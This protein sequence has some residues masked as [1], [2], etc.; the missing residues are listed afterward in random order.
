VGKYDAA[1][2]AT[3]DNKTRRMRFACWITKATD[4]HSE[5]LILIAF[6]RLRESA[7]MLRYM[8]ISSLVYFKTRPPHSMPRLRMR[9]AIP[10]LT[11]IPFTTVSRSKGTILFQFSRVTTSSVTAANNEVQLILC[12]NVVIQLLQRK[13][14][15]G[16]RNF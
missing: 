14:K 12:S 2:E 5:Y 13:L 15:A 11:P 3:R 6:P 7:F 8:Y 10:P 4:T 1:Q 16:F 9:G